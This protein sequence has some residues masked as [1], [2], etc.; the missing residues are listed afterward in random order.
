[1]TEATRSAEIR[2]RLSHPVLDADGHYVEY[3]PLML[4]IMREV[5]GQRLVDH[6]GVRHPRWYALSDAQR[7]ARR[8]TRPP[9][10]ALPSANTLDSA[11]SV[12]PR[13]LRARM[14]E[15]GLD[16]AVLYPSNG[17]GAAHLSDEELR[18]GSCRS[19]NT[20]IAEVFG[21]HADRMTP[22]A[23]IPMHTPA[24]AVEELEFAA[25]KGL[26]TIVMAS[27][28][29]RPIQDRRQGAYL[30]VFALDSDYDYDPVWAK[31]VELRLAPTFHSGGM[32]WG[33]RMSP[34]T[35]MY[36]HV[37][38]FAAASEAICKALF[39]GGVTRRFPTL[40]F[41][42]LEGGVGWGVDLFAGLV[43][44]F[45]KR[46]GGRV[47]NYDPERFDK[48]MWGELFEQYAEGRMA[49]LT[50]PDQLED[51][52]RRLGPGLQDPNRLD[53]FAAAGIVQPEDIAARFVPNFYFG[54]EADDPV[55]AWAF[56]A[57]A[58]PFG[59]T[60]RAVFSSD[61]GHW[62]VPD[63]REVLEEAYELVEH[64]LLTDA[65]FRDFVFV[66]TARLYAGTNPEF[67]KGTTVEAA[68]AGLQLDG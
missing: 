3:M 1:M 48:A 33:S 65:D 5:G 28:V 43:G 61:I 46:G 15:I 39:F 64:E 55:N 11:T 37:G 38:H 24:E 7:Q 51:P 54:C 42:F 22:A 17:L 34:S 6:Y 41:G 31:C 35:Y 67:F 63:M 8:Y 44:R 36:N 45:D 30:D 13:L 9:W 10:W 47:A 21:P 49:S 14:D 53:D 57:K 68:I 32:G 19:W 52:W 23:V 66:N 16:Y 26:K 25:G 56:A 60:I 27:H 29:I 2:S 20:Y 40:R 4:E 50:A 58:N 18:R 59:Q 62:D 12:L